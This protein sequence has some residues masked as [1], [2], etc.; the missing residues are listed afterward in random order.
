MSLPLLRR[1]QLIIPAESGE[2][3]KGGVLSGSLSLTRPGIPA[4][5]GMTV[6]APARKRTLS[7]VRR[8]ERPCITAQRAATLLK[9]GVEYGSEP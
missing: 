3:G 1:A 8:I 9:P 7:F 5:A 4:F 2:A 6:G